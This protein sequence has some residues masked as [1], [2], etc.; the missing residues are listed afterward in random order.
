MCIIFT[1]VSLPFL[2]W[3]CKAS[4]VSF[5]RDYTWTQTHSFFVLMGGFM[6]YVNEKPYHTLQPDE[7]LKL[8]HTGCIG[9]TSLSTCNVPIRCT[10]SRPMSQRITLVSVTE[11]NTL[12][13][14]I[15]HSTRTCRFFALIGGFI[16]NVNGE[17]HHSLLRY[18]S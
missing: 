17:L 11:T 2:W 10:G 8:I 3:S 7:V 9:G 16:L 1:D 4:Q 5:L 13:P 14:K 18:S 6:L 15:I 12:S